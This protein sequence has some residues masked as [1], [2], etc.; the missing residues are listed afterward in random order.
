MKENDDGKELALQTP[1]DSIITARTILWLNF[2]V[3]F[4]GSQWLKWGDIDYVLRGG[5]K[6]ALYRF[7][8][9]HF[10]TSVSEDWVG[11]IRLSTWWEWD[12]V[13][14]EDTSPVLESGGTPLMCLKTFCHMLA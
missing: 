6:F 7:L 3:R 8:A 2:G 1:D 12:E 11:A 14:D 13:G 4:F 9:A 5:F 10:V